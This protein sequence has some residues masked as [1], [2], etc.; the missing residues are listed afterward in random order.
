MEDTL[1]I[2]E[3]FLRKIFNAI[4]SMLLIVDED[5]R[6]WH[7][8]L[9]ASH[10]IGI[11]TDIYKE[12]GG[13]VLHCLNALNIFGG[14][15]HSQNCGECILR[16]SVRKAISGKTVYQQETFMKLMTKD[17]DI[18][19]DMHVLLTASP[20]EYED[21]TYVLLILEDIS[22][23]VQL[24]SLVPVCPSCRK[25]RDDKDYINKAEEYISKHPDDLNNAVCPDCAKKD[26][27]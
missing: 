10:K 18:L 22:E 15:G 6:I 25:I 13:E 8:N 17:K 11:G 4:P 27:P 2:K 9:A 19:S 1:L 16:N 3:K 5:V 24:R 14:C 20:F 7:L 21:K 23:L 12:R 26:L